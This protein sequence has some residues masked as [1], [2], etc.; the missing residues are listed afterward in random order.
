MH[1]PQHVSLKEQKELLQLKEM[2]LYRDELK[3]ELQE[4]QQE[5]QELEE[6]EQQT[7]AAAKKSSRSGKHAPK[8]PSPLLFSCTASEQR[9]NI[10]HTPPREH[11][12]KTEEPL[13]PRLLVY[14][15]ERSAW[16]ALKKSVKAKKALENPAK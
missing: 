15:A 4:I 12:R 5:L 1:S 9:G 10:H 14:L 13:L 8:Y 3:E 7:S 11:E 2:E 16:E 6:E